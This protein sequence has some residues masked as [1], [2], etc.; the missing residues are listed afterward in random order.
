M[1]DSMEDAEG[2]QEDVAASLKLW[3]TLAR[4][5][6]WVAEQTRRHIEQSGLSPSEFGVLELLYH[7]GPLMIGEIGGRVLLSSGSMTYVVDKL[8]GRGLLRRQPSGDDRRAV[9]VELTREGST[10]IGGIFPEHVQLVRRAT[11]GLTLEEKRIAAALLRRLGKH[12][13]GMA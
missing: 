11:A 13:E 6:R 9:V 12:A 8:E 4:A 5:K 3:I 10:M 2:D 1:N 7:K